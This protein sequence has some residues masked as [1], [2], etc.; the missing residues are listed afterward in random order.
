MIPSLLLEYQ[1]LTVL[2]DESR[3]ILRE[4]ANIQLMDV[5]LPASTGVEFER[6]CVIISTDH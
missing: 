6:R 5:I 2:G 1:S 3:R 4:S